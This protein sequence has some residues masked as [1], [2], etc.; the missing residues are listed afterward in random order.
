MRWFT[1]GWACFLAGMARISWQ[2]A[3]RAGSCDCIHRKKE[4]T[5]ASRWLRVEM[6]LC[7]LV[8]SQFRNPAMAASSMRS[9]VSL[10][11][12]MDLTSLKKAISSLN[13]SR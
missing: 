2:L 8:S 4:L 12:G 10:S 6:L 9:R 1:P 5:A 3:I 11:G 7:L 13:A